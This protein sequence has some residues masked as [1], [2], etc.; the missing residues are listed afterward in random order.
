MNKGSPLQVGFNSL[1]IRALTWGCKIA[2]LEKWWRHGNNRGQR[3][4][5]KMALSTGGTVWRAGKRKKHPCVSW[6]WATCLLLSHKV[7]L[8][9][10]NL[11]CRLVMWKYD[12]DTV[13]VWKGDAAA[14]V[15]CA[16]RITQFWKIPGEMRGGCKQKCS[17]FCWPVFLKTKKKLFLDAFNWWSQGIQC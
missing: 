2:L 17:S 12:Q 8:Y 3:F 4:V 10:R 11:I 5:G 1:W 9:R 13:V 16:S 15:H 14:W 6:S 7:Y